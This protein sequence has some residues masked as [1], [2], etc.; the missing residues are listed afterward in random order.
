MVLTVSPDYLREKCKVEVSDKMLGTIHNNSEVS[1]LGNT[2]WLIGSIESFDIKILY[3]V[4]EKNQE[5]AL[6]I[7]R[8]N[9]SKGMVPYLH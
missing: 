1:V 3:Y 7:T 8:A 5:S 2:S 9:Q 4:L 6:S